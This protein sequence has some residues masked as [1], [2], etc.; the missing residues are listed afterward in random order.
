MTHRRT[1]WLLQAIT[2]YALWY[3]ALIALGIVFAIPLLWMF[4]VSLHD[5]AGVFAE[6]FRWIPEKVEWRNYVDAVSLL[7]FGRYLLNTVVITAFV[8]IGIVLSSSLVAYGF[9]RLRFR[10]RNKLFTLCIA[11][12]MLPGQVTMIPLY[13]GF[14][15]LGWVD[16]FLPL[17]VPAFFGSPFYIFLLRQFFLTIP[18]EYDEAARLDGAG[19]LRIYWSIILPLAKPALATVALFAF[20]GTWNDFFNPLIYLNSPENATL[21]LGLNMMK[22]QVIGTGVTQWQ[23]L[24]AASLLVMLPNII[25]FFFAQ[26]HFMKGIHVGG[27]KG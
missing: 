1:N 16:T 12:M 18:R 9:S 7:P 5:L 20:L 17:I 13:I 27:L 3:A 19:K 21:T 2:R 6:P 26:K 10:G 14:A 24:M 23:L 11:T 22:S 8:L 25:L 4:S 15:K